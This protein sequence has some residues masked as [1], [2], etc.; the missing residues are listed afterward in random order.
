MQ[1]LKCT[2]CG[3]FNELKSEFQ[4]FCTHCGQKLEP[5]YTQWK[6]G[7]PRANFE[8]F[9]EA[10]GISEQQKLH[11]EEQARVKPK[12]KVSKLGLVLGIFVLFFGAL[13]VAGYFVK[14]YVLNY[15]ST[16]AETHQDEILT[17]IH[18]KSWETYTCGSLGLTLQSPMPLQSNADQFESM[19]V[20]ARQN[21]VTM[22]V[23][24]MDNPIVHL[25]ISATS[26]QFVEG[27]Q[28]SVDRAKEGVLG[29]LKEAATNVNF[30]ANDTEITIQSM[31]A[32]L[33]SGTF[34][35]DNTPRGFLLLTLTDGLKLYQVFV[36]YD[37]TSESGQQA[38]QKVME[39]VQIKRS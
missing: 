1:Y 18:D 9:V 20:E 7:N 34:I 13:S 28:V 33:T 36:M 3:G 38:A 29:Q 23:Y 4:T 37:S 19:P 31:P 24:T 32:T 35:E 11:L 8:Q 30:T 2:E 39:S 5:N 25:T 10:M 27:V 6:K 26:A 14:P 15:I 21:I 22:D 12:R 17:K 16:F